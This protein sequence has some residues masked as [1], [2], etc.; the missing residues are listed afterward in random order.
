M[1]LIFVGIFFLLFVCAVLKH[2]DILIIVYSSLQMLYNKM[3]ATVFVRCVT[4]NWSCG[5]LQGIKCTAKLEYV[6]GKRV[7][8]KAKTS[9]C[10]SN[11]KKCLQFKWE[12]T[13]FKREFLFSILI[14]FC[15]MQNNDCRFCHLLRL[16]VFTNLFSPNGFTIC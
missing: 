13:P 15:A 11:K 10:V 7:G 9:K 14:T 12:K 4:L 1:G 5:F 6:N 2:S 16:S 3:N 8:R